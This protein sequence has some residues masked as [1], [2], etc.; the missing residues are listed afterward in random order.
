MATEH[1]K[2]KVMVIDAIDKNVWDLVSQVPS[3]SWPVVG[4]NCFLNLILPGTGT[5][6]MACAGNE[7]VSKTQLAIGLL[8]FM[9]SVFLVGWI[10]ALYWSYLSVKRRMDEDKMMKQGGG[11]ENQYLQ[12][13]IPMG[14]GARAQAMR[15]LNQPDMGHQYNQPIGN[16]NNQPKS[17]YSNFDQ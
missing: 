9:T 3:C 4:A 12:N 2:N 10:W 8:Q 17:S 11:I 13:E 15:Y 14:S 7:S 6:V 16:F 1:F 5:W